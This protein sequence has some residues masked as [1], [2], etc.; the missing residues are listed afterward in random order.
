MYLS[1]VQC[2]RNNRLLDVVKWKNRLVLGRYQE[3]PPPSPTALLATSRHA[4]Y[5]RQL[6][7][8]HTVLYPRRPTTHVVPLRIY[9]L[10]YGT[11]CGFAQ[12]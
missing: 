8:Y 2:M 9:G 7:P 3:D 10:I 6:K 12:P 1:Y 4:G 11:W 5:N